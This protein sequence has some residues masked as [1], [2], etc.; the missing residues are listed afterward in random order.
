MVAPR[1]AGSSTL[2][3]RDGAAGRRG[4]VSG[5]V[6]AHTPDPFTGFAPSAYQS[7]P[8]ATKRNASPSGT[9]RPA[10]GSGKCAVHTSV[11]VSQ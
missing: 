3:A 9:M 5:R 4:A 1:D 11:S 6:T 2:P 8:S 7:R 10:D